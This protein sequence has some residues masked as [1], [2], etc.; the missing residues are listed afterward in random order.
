MVRAAMGICFEEVP[1][2]HV[3]PMPYSMASNRLSVLWFGRCLTNSDTELEELTC[4]K[5]RISHGAADQ[6]SDTLRSYQA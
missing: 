3:K 1:S 4:L 2:P 6:L 5:H